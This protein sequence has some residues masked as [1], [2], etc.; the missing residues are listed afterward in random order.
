METETMIKTE[1][2]A[3]AI[4]ENTGTNCKG[5]A[6][7]GGIGG[8]IVC[9]YLIYRFAAKPLIKK[10]KEKRAANG[11]ETKANSKNDHTENET[12]E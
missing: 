1:E 4:T 12:E 7:V 2:V 6:V 10:I 9:G 5:L 3:E 11:K 8:A